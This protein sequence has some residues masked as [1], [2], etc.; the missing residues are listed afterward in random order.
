VHF[1]YSVSVDGD[2]AV[3]GAYGDDDN[4]QD[5]GSAYVFTKDDGGNKPAICCD[6]VLNWEDI[7]AGE[8]VE[9]EVE[10]WNCGMDFS[11]L[12]WEIESYP[13]WGVWTFIP[14]SG[15][16]LTPDDG[17]ITIDIEVVAPD[18]PETEFKGEIKIVNSEDVNE[19]CTIDASLATPKNQIYINYQSQFMQFMISI[20]KNR[21]IRNTP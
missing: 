18:D 9:G 20:Y 16:N 8:L 4:G 3:I 10:V 7:E 21:Y 13:D 19:Y 6:G 1:G 14:D 12:D 15:E 11:E 5:S 2:Y 17:E